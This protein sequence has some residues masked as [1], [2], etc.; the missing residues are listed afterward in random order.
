MIE[1]DAAGLVHTDGET[2]MAAA[3]VEVAVLPR[4]LRVAVPADC[5]AVASLSAASHHAF[6]LQF[7]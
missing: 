2:H 3:E 6:A 4:S 7:P 5:H 1:R